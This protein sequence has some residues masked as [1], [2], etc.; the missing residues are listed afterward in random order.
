[1]SKS[2]IVSTT[3]TIQRHLCPLV[4]LMAGQLLSTRYLPGFFMGLLSMVWDST[5][6]RGCNVNIMDSSRPP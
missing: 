6:D 2:R 3:E 1:M 4:M 5:V